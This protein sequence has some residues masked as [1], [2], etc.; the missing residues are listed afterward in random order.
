MKSVACDIVGLFAQAYGSAQPRGRP[1]RV[2]EQSRSQPLRS[3]A[4]V[5]SPR[6]AL[7]EAAQL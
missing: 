3:S 6:L 4:S 5:C 2:R 7:V 1:G